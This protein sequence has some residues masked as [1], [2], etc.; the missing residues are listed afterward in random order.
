MFVRNLFKSIKR[1]MPTFEITA[2]SGFSN[3][4]SGDAIEI[5]SN[6]AGDTG[7][8]TLWG[9]SN[10]KTDIVYEEIQ[11]K[12]TT[13]VTTSKTDWGNLYGAFLGKVDGSNMKAAVGTITI[14]EASADQ[15]IT[16]I[17]TTKYSVGMIGFFIPHELIEIYKV[18]GNLWYN[19]LELVSSANGWPLGT[20][21]EQLKLK[22]YIFLISDG[23]GAT[24]KIKVYDLM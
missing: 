19:P 5:V 9:S 23:S 4:P 17:A 18:S 20:S 12:G 15:T 10:G 8:I 1:I 11:L 14:R 21:P 2:Y 22:D 13:V 6:N 24:A 3:Q 16:T 7:W